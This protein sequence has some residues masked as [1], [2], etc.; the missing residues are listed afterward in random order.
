MRTHAHR[1]GDEWV[2]SGTKQWISSSPHASAAILF[3]VT[4]ADQE[5]ARKGGISCFFVPMHT[6]G[7]RIDS[8]IKVYGESGGNE[9][10]I[11]FS[12]V[13][14]PID[15]L[16]GEENRGLALALSG[17]SRGRIFNSGRT[18]GLAR[19]A[20]ESALEYAESRHTFGSPLIEYQGISFPLAE[21]A[22]EIYAAR[23]LA[24][25]CAKKLDAGENAVMELAMAKAYCS[26]VCYRAYDQAIQT[27]GA[28]GITNEVK[29]YNGWHQART[30][31]IADG[32]AEMMRRMIV[33]RLAKGD[34]P[35]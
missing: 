8:V 29:L 1:D 21:N 14:V 15:H 9:A 2:I 16:I 10:I 30:Q 17:V 25:D 6:E 26:E 7:V 4:D 27:H 11:S 33:S 20:L 24:I 5:R 13:R 3:A 35:F 18:V 22:M 19:W 31:R 34:R 12:D 23:C 28:M 32:S